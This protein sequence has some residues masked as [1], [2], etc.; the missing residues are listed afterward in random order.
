MFH[1]FASLTPGKNLPQ[2]T[3]MLILGLLIGFGGCGVTS[4]AGNDTFKPTGSPD[5]MSITIHTVVPQNNEQAAI[6]IHDTSLV[7][8]LYATIYALPPMPAQQA[9]TA[10]GGPSYTLTFSQ[11]ATRLVQLQADR[12]G[13]RPIYIDNPTQARQTTTDFWN[14]LDSIIAEGLPTPQIA[15]AAVKRQVSPDQPPQTARLASAQTAQQLYQAIIDLHA[16]AQNSDPS[17][18]FDYEVVFHTADQAIP[19]L[20]SVQHK[21]VRLE[22]NFHSH[23]GT[24]AFDNNFQQVLT[25]ALT[26]ETFAPAKPDAA[27]LTVTTLQASSHATITNA[28]QLQQLYGKIL[29]LPT[30]QPQADCP[31]ES[32]KLAGKFTWY[33]FTQWDLPIMHIDAYAGSCQSIDIGWA[34]A[35]TTN[36]YLQGDE[37]FWLL[38]RALAGQR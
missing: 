20:I 32:D 4:N 14:Q 38:L 28:T 29:S 21:L 27:T 9:C 22:G 5:S 3:A 36:H 31:S 33:Y 35:I 1:K 26:G 24:Y 2:L 25:N 13:C 11:G 16:T 23:T 30:I 10:D 8:H 12:F 34:D 15:W 37:S 17:D 6:L 19:A 18:S 7:Q